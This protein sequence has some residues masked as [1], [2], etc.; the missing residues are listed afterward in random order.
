MSE[1]K[2][3]V[4]LVIHGAGEPAR[5][6]GRVYWAPLLSPDLGPK[7]EVRAPVMPDPEHPDDRAWRDAIGE[8]LRGL[9]SPVLVGHSFGASTLL[10]FIAM[11]DPLPAIRGLFLVAAPFWGKKFPDFMLTPAHLHRLQSVSPMFFYRSTDDEVVD[12]AQF[13]KFQATLPNAVFRELEGRGHIFEQDRFPEL[14]A[15]I[16]ATLSRDPEASA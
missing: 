13:H 9:H 2:R 4:V 3:D 12:A 15:D 1:D 14:A 10:R 5:R 7:V 6:D 8:Q 16:R 11:A